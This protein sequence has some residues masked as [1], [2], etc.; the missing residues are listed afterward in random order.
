MTDDFLPDNTSE[1]LFVIATWIAVTATLY[2]LLAQNPTIGFQAS[3]ALAS[4]TTTQNNPVANDMI[5]FQQ[6]S[7]EQVNKAYT[8]LNTFTD[9]QVGEQAYCITREN[10][11]TVG[12]QQAGTIESN[13]SSVTFTSNNCEGIIQGYLH[14]HP[15]TSTTALSQTDKETLRDNPDLLSCV[16]NAPVTEESDNIAC[17]QIQ[18]EKITE[19][20]V[21]TR[22]T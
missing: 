14:F 4:L 18:E 8:D 3:T 21:Q 6:S 2:V 11:E 5:T 22:E 13:E 7:I 9:D 16:M 1:T 12:L 20:Q 15:P 19:I 17:Y 10:S